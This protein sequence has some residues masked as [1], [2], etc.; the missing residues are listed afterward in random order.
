MMPKN[1]GPFVPTVEATAARPREG[2]TPPDVMAKLHELLAAARVR[3][4]PRYQILM[5]EISG[6]AAKEERGEIV[7]RRAS[8]PIPPTTRIQW[9]ALAGVGGRNR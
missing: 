7:R 4:W 5:A 2:P 6:L 1:P 9:P 3:D 8:N